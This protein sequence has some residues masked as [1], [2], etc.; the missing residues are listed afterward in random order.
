MDTK[1]YIE[2]IVIIIAMISAFSAA[3]AA[4]QSKRAV[5]IS[6][7]GI[8]SNLLLVQ[9]EKYASEKMKDSLRQVIDFYKENKTDFVK[10]YVIKQKKSKELDEARRTVKFIFLE[11][12]NLWETKMFKENHL[13]IL[14]HNRN[15]SILLQIIKPIEFEMNKNNIDIEMY[16]FYEKKFPLAINEK[17][18]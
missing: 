2:V 3:Y 8:V 6:L 18:D 9:R 16:S 13:R 7:N 11:N 10:E 17:I 5:E 15:V 12:F 1:E 4:R 14:M